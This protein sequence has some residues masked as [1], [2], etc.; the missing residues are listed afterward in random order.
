MD[1]NKVDLSLVPEFRAIEK[2]E[3]SDYD[4]NTQKQ[5][6]KL[7]SSINITDNSKILNYGADIQQ[8]MSSF[9]DTALANVRNKDLD[10]VGLIISDLVVELKGFSFD[11]EKKGLAKVFSKFG[12]KIESFKT[13]YATIEKN[14]D[15]IV[16]KLEGH[17]I[18]LTKDV[19]MFDRLYEE[20]LNYFK[21]LNLYIEAGKAKLIEI[22]QN[23]L[24]EL[25][26]KA[27]ASGKQE[28]AQI[29]N[30]LSNSINR[31]E[32]KIYDL[33]L[34]GTISMQMAP[35][36]RLVQNNDY[37]MIDKIH[38][39]I[40][41]TIPIWK[42][43]MVL[44]LGLAHS[45]SAIKAQQ[46]VSETTNELLKKNA[47]MLKTGTVEA[48]R[49]SEKG[50]VEIETLV[51]VNQNLIES[52][53]EFEAIQEEGKARRKAAAEQLVEIKTELGN[54]LLEVSNQN[55]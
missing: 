26:A 27:E 14:L 8:K 37:E 13:R 49:E 46:Q 42:N 45:K 17:K 44:A 29:L 48:A 28:D 25:R 9:S 30:D 18:T 3:A 38:T 41:N 31:F 51:E 35:Q 10:D 2:A 43:Q 39:S 24:E 54:K 23:E 50:I 11:E 22:K 1:E 33:E 12:N 19:K 52:L 4:E 40:V 32:K 7:A 55:G 21:Q 15:D 36:I 16:K 6:T 34:T 53:D 20:N 47:E 5:I